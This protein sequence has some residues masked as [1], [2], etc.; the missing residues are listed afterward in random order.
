MTEKNLRYVYIAGPITKGSPFENVKRAI[1]EGD[2][3]VEHGFFPFV[4]HLTA[5]WAMVAGDKT[6]EKWLVYDEAW[7]LKCDCVLRLEG[8]SLGADR[9]VEFAKKHGIPVFYSTSDLYAARKAWAS[10]STSTTG[11]VPVAGPSQPSIYTSVP[12]VENNATKMI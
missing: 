10:Q 4:P 9:E 6:F 8:E 5:L 11:S 3:L 2:S 7:L 1:L 12:T